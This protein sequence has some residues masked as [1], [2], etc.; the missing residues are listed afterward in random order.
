MRVR[1]VEYGNRVTSSQLLA[2]GN[3]SMERAINRSVNVGVLVPILAILAVMACTGGLTTPPG[4]VKYSDELRTFS[5]EYPREWQ[6]VT[7]QITAIE[8]QVKDVIG[9]LDFS[10]V[11]FIADDVDSANQV[12]IFVESLQSEMT[13]DEYN[14]AVSAF[15]KERFPS[16][17][18]QRSSKV[19]VDGKSA[20]LEELIFE[21]SDLDPRLSGSVPYTRLIFVLGNVGWVLTCSYPDDPGFAQ[22]CEFIVRTLR[23]LE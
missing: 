21:A 7:S 19:Q 12:E 11:V 22:T 5:I 9:G 1:L 18:V 15:S 13:V 3:E 8:G 23:I 14:E 4:F 20:V 10:S 2:Q 17:K 6:L 16:L